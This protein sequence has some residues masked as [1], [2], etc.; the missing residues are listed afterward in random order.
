MLSP[1]APLSPYLDRLF[2]RRFQKAGK[3]RDAEP[4]TAV[5]GVLAQATEPG[6]RA[7][8]GSE[9]HQTETTEVMIHALSSEAL[10]GE[11]APTRESERVFTELTL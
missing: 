2:E 5:R 11:R 1:H 8:A 4:H 10:R 6:A 7:K 9:K 3:Q